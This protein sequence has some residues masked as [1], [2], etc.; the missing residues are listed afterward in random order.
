LFGC[1]FSRA[2]QTDYRFLTPRFPAQTPSCQLPVFD[3]ALA[4][5]FL[6][7]KPN[8]FADFRGVENR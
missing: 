4:H 7:E 1:T 3:A 5:D 8:D 2:P 6:P